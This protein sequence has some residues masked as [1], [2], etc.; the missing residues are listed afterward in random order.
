[1][2]PE[3]QAASE[4]VPER[5][6]VRIDSH[7]V[8]EA[9]DAYVH[10]HPGASLFHGRSWQRALE[11]TFRAYRPVHR[12]ALRG[13]RVC[14]VLP[15]YRVPT[16]PFGCAL[17]SLPLG[18]YGGVCADDEEAARA[19]VEDA[20]SLAKSL[21]ARY[22]EL[23]QEHPLPGLPTK[24]LYVS[25]RRAIH[26]DRE[27][28]LAEVPRKQ[29]ASIRAGEKR[30]LTHR[31]G[32][33]ELLPLFYE[34]FSISMRDLGS[35]VMPRR[36]FQNLLE[37][38][39]PQASIL[40]VFARDRMVAGVLSFYHRDMVMPY[41]AA[42]TPES[43]ALNAHDYMYWTLMCDA[44]ERGFRVFDFGRSKKES[45]PYHFKRHWG[46]EP[47]SLPYQYLLVRQRTMPNLSPTNPRFS[48]AIR[49]WQRA[50]LGLTRWLG[51]KLL[52]YFP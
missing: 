5:G 38:Y 25:F 13:D 52:P 21:G 43:A 32:G 47:T 3:A 7:P 9:W 30:G 44:A 41:Y 18:V 40:A 39:G 27:A 29:R 45:G 1:M 15:L 51:P 12:I 28:N 33:T 35:P 11:R 22:V 19:L 34:G 42:S 2:R 37:A 23:R 8:P 10:G 26:P 16:L 24:D 49:A 46:F 6:P 31:T 36:F 50:P 48:L 17:V 20:D 14:G 4:G